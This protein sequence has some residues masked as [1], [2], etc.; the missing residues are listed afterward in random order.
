M[1]TQLISIQHTIHISVL[2]MMLGTV[3]N[4]VV[5]QP[6]NEQYL[7]IHANNYPLNTHEYA[8]AITRIHLLSL[9]LNC[10]II[11]DGAKT[12]FNKSGKFIKFITY[13]QLTKHFT[14]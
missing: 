11:Q 12:V 8:L 1:Q 5:H 4:A 13:D 7:V 14:V 9:F 10:K 3:L 6:N 2:T